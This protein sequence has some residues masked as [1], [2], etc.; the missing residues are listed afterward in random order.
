MSDNNTKELPKELP[1]V[2]SLPSQKIYSLTYNALI[3]KIFEACE[4]GE[5]TVTLHENKES[6][7]TQ[8]E[9]NEIESKGYSMRWNCLQDLYTF[10][11]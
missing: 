8:E 9:K 6:P 2:T 10:K 11:F 3:E 4:R 7:L 1:F 5:R